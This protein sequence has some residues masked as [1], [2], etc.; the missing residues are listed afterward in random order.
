MKLM[1]LMIVNAPTGGALVQTNSTSLIEVDEIEIT[2][3]SD[4]NDNDEEDNEEEKEGKSKI[5]LSK[6]LIATK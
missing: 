2:S 5:I 4:D 1:L 3:L 6:R